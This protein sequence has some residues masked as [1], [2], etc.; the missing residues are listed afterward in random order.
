[1][2]T[3]LIAIILFLL[4]L[5]LE[6]QTSVEET[7][8]NSNYPQALAYLEQGKAKYREGDYRSAVIAY[9]KALELQDSLVDAYIQ[10]ASAK[11]ILED[12]EGALKD[13]SSVI[14]LDSA[15][16]SA[17]YYRSYLKH[18]LGFQ[19][20]SSLQD[21][22]IAI[23]LA[24][25]DAKLYARRAYIKAHTFDLE[26]DKINH[27]S[28]IED[29]DR[30]IELNNSNPEFYRQRGFSKSQEGE[31]LAAAADFEKAI[32]LDPGNADNY[33]ERGL[34]RLKIEDFNGAVEDFSKAIEINDDHEY[35][36][37]NLGLAK[38]NN[39]DYYGAID[40]YTTA[41]E[42]ISEELRTKKFDRVFKF[43]LTNAYIMRGASFIALRK[44]YEACADFSQSYELGEKRALNY[45]K[46]YCRP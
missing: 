34:I 18:E 32:I 21:I 22:N 12:Y 45:L 3:R 27:E 29:L 30:A 35:L 8:S 13:Y 15:N 42:L 26:A 38:Y 44:M 14:R 20:D 33:N 11:S 9:N 24:P 40:S 10:R 37:R 4:P 25:D 36:F 19:R 5:G 6:A 1:M 2:H 43:K 41:I 7:V 28:A 17:Y 39:K 23:E 16:I 46:K 31:T